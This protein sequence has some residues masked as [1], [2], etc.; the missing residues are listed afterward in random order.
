M[1]IRSTVRTILLASLCLAGLMAAPAQA[2]SPC[3]G[4][5]AS[6]PDAVL[7]GAQFGAAAAVAGNDVLIG[8]PGSAAV[9]VYRR[10]TNG[11]YA[12]A[13][14]LPRPSALLLNSGF[15]SDIAVD[16]NI[17]VV[18]APFHNDSQ[19]AVV[20]YS[21]SSTGVWSAM[22]TIASPIDLPD[23]AFGFSVAMSG[24]YLAVGAPGALNGAAFARGVVYMYARQPDGT[25]TFASR[26]DP[27]FPDASQNKFFGW[28]VGLQL[29]TLV[30]AAPGEMLGTDGGKPGTAYVFR[31]AQLG[32]WSQLTRVKSTGSANW[33]FGTDVAVGSEGVDGAGASI[34]IREQRVALPDAV[35]QY[36]TTNSMPNLVSAVEASATPAF[37]GDPQ[38]DIVLANS[39]GVYEGFGLVGSPDASRVD[40]YIFGGVTWAYDTSYTLAGGGV[41]NGFGQGVAVGH[42]HIAMGAPQY[43]YGLNDAPGFISI[44]THDLADCNNDGTTDACVIAAGG[45]AVDKNSDGVPDACQLVSAPPIMGATQGNTATGVLLAWPEM[46]N[47]VRYKISLAV[48]GGETVLGYSYIAQYLDTAA[49]VGVLRTYRVRTENAAGTL[50]DGF[51]AASGWR[52]VAAPTNVVATNGTSLASVGVSWTASTGATA[53]KVIRTRG[54]EVVTVATTAG[55][56]YNDASATAGLVYSYAVRAVCPLGESPLS[57]SDTGFRAANAAATSVAASDGLSSS[58]VEV[59]WTA[60]EG[61]TTSYTILRQEGSKKAKVLGTAGASVRTFT[62]TSGKVGKVYKYIVRLS[63]ATTGGLSDNGWKARVGPSGAAA[64]DGSSATG[65]TVT[66]SLAPSATKATGYGIYRAVGSGTAVLVGSVGKKV[67]TFTDFSAVP[68]VLY[69]YSVRAAAQGGLTPP[70]SNTGWRALSP[71]AVL[72]ASDGTYTTK[73]LV[74]WPNVTGATSYLIA[75]TGGGAPVQFVSVANSFN[76]TTAT[77][78]TVYTYTV[79]SV[80]AL[81]TSA[82]SASN[83]GY[84]AAATTLL[85]GGPG[86]GAGAINRAGGGGAVGNN[87]GAGGAGGTGSEAVPAADDEAA[88]A[89]LDGALYLL[90]DMRV[91]SGLFV[92]GYDDR[93]IAQLHD[94]ADLAHTTLLVV[95]GDAVLGGGLKLQFAG[96]EPK[97]GDRWTLVI[98]SR[99]QGDFRVVRPEGLPAGTRV[100]VRSN[101]TVLQVEIKSA[102]GG[103]A[104]E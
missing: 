3:V 67:V 78:T 33:A 90:S 103:G 24:G 79:K 77:P 54:S 34:F 75:R 20:L 63:T 89:A 57:A 52:A 32:G 48:G 31:R 59:V 18:G 43:E 86:A 62:D 51:V 93:L 19:G 21:R 14:Q 36:K 91:E 26:F 102:E 46:P 23:G 6:V 15:G 92:M 70:S 65:V 9:F 35:W 97:V 25:Y 11:A 74:Q 39:L 84:R 69:T 61:G 88:W 83:T 45:N 37:A 8:A 96:Y 1:S 28:S 72:A 16:G 47:G 7:D 82:A 55:T 81:G 2:G 68:G 5:E 29:S 94:P 22:Q 101:G 56:G 100:E 41:A 30:V 80:C 87:H 66:W 53:Y 13:A 73:V 17:A 60:P 10:G 71:P 12:I 85:A 98:A 58:G 44:R 38:N 64:T 76:D 104:A 40:Q 50:S 27:N 49:T 42:D 4:T 99:I 95:T